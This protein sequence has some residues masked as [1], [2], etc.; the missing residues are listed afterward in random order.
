MK[1]SVQAQ[2]VKRIERLRKIHRDVKQIHAEEQKLKKQRK[3]QI[4]Q[5]REKLI[6]ERLK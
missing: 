2:I 6:A 1:I 4:K 5:R 3:L